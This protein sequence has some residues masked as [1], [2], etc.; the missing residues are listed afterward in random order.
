M[1]YVETNCGDGVLRPVFTLGDSVEECCGMPDIVSA[2]E[3]DTDVCSDC[4]KELREW[5]KSF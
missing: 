1:C 2:R 3:H 4:G 5:T